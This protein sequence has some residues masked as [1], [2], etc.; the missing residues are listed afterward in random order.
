M[1]ISL[2]RRTPLFPARN[3][4]EQDKNPLNADSFFGPG[5]QAVHPETILV[6]TQ[7]L[8]A[9]TMFLAFGLRPQGAG[10]SHRKFSPSTRGA[11]RISGQKTF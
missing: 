5:A 4:P 10:T 9:R 11:T 8:G 1:V 7:R 6:P 2:L 3:V